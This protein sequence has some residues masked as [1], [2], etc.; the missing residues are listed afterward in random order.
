MLVPVYFARMSPEGIQEADSNDDLPL[1]RATAHC[2]QGIT[3]T[4]N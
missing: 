1:R 4:Q 2:Q 3:Y